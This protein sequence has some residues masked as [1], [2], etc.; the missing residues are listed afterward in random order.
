MR[1]WQIQYEVFDRRHTAAD[2]ATA[3]RKAQAENRAGAIL[4]AE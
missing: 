3:Y 4:V 2:L 1:T